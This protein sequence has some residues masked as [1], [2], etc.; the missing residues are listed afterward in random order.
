MAISGPLSSYPIF[1]LGGAIARVDEDATAFGGRQ[2]GHTFNFAASTE[3]EDGFEEQRDW[4]RQS[5]KS[6]EP[7]HSGVYVNFLGD[8][9][10][11]RIREMYGAAK[12]AR[13]QALKREYDPD[14]LFHLNQ[15]IPPA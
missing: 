11:D 13:L 1:Q 12:Y 14:N 10:D 5:W 6:L 9:G 15:N 8:E 2:S 3:T 4:A 7:H